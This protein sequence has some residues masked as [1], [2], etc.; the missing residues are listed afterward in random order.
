MTDAPFRSKIY[1]GSSRQRD[2]A[3]DAREIATKSIAATPF[4][5]CDPA[6]IPPRQWLYGRHYI[7]QFLTCT[8]SHSGMGKTSL[9]ITDALA[10]AS[11]RPLLGVAPTERARVWI[12]NGEHPRDE[13]DRRIAAAMQQHKLT[14]QDIG[15]YLFLNCRETPI[16]LA[17]QTRAGIVIAQSVAEE[18][19]A[20]IK[21][22]R[23]DVLVVD[24]FIRSH[25]VGES[26]NSAIDSVVSLWATIADKTNCS[27]E[28]L[29]HS[30][31][32]GNAEATIEDARGA[33]ALISASRSARVLNRM[34]ENEAK[35]AGI[36]PSEAWRYFRVE[37]GKAS[38]ATRPE[39]ADWYRLASN[40]LANGDHVGSVVAWSWPDP[41]DGVSVHDLRAAQ[42]A[43][44]QGGPWRADIRADM[45]V[46]KPIAKALG[47][48]VRKGADREKVKRLLKT[49]TENGMF[50]H[51]E[52]KDTDRH[53][54][55][56]VEV[57]QWADD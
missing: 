43:V 10:M 35:R 26:D 52:R 46:G 30:R 11:G 24:P 38:M 21:Q 9:A 12:W 49:W 4:I 25:R 19:I 34:T 6:R 37:N 3:P 27:I 18:I 5:Y 2:E 31:K 14:A 1:D 23:I 41:F 22:N 36:S 53:S 33:S 55:V 29:H 15:D 47:L 56:F 57:G 13:L 16:T 51:V 42:Q 54:Y 44:S 20:T 45:W 40:I 32:T 48:N 17:T 50:E 8:I 39:K 7:R 28:L